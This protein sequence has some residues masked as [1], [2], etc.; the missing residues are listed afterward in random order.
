MRRK[1]NNSYITL[2]TERLKIV[3]LSEKYKQE[4]FIEFTPAITRYMFPKSPETI[5][6]TQ[7]FI[8]ASLMNM[9]KGTEMIWAILQ[10]NEF[11]GVC[12][13]HKLDS[14]AP[15]LGIWLKKS[16]HG[17]GYGREAMSAVYEW[18]TKNYS[19]EYIM[20]PVDRNNIS[21]RKIAESLGGTIEMEYPKKNQSGRILDIVEYHIK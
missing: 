12:G 14:P 17:K 21:S 1:I 2:H 6:D 7:T 18:V 5:D 4:I 20:Y 10:E 16:A 13:A 9:K 11:V 15:E 8:N 3:P 19:Y